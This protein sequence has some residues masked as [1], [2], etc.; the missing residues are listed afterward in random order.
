MPVTSIY[1]Q[2]RSTAASAAAAAAAARDVMA[3]TLAVSDG[4]LV[5]ARDLSATSPARSL[6]R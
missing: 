4:Q 6:N 2:H 3:L 5:T 1:R